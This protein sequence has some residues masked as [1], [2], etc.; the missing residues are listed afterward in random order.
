[1]AG[2]KVYASSDA[3]R[4]S[5]RRR[6]KAIHGLPDL[7]QRKIRTKT[8]N[9]THRQS[10]PEDKFYEV[11]RQRYPLTQRQVPFA[12]LAIDFFIPELDTYLQLD[13]VYW[14]G[15]DR[16]LRELA[17]RSS[18]QGVAIMANWRRDRRQD[19]AFAAAGVRLVRLTDTQVAKATDPLA[20]LCA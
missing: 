8:R 12:G 19:A 4:D 15:L 5:L 10:R 1:M 11:L 20:L 2:I 7:A 6:I 14:H 13:G 9:G 17:S 18:R 3:G 16:P